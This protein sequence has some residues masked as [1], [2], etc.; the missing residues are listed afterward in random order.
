MGTPSID[1]PRATMR[2]GPPAIA[3]AAGVRSLFVAILVVGAVACAPERTRD[4]LPAPRL[5]ESAD[6]LAERVREEFAHAWQAYAKH[7]WGYDEVLPLSREGHNWYGQSLLITPVDALDA[8]ILL[9]F[10]DEADRVRA[11]VHE[12]L[13]FDI[14]ADVQ[15]FEVTIRVLG[16]LLSGYQLSGDERLLELA[17]DLGRRLLPAFD[18]PTAM[19]YGW[20]NLRTGDV[21]RARTYTAEIG[22][23]ILEFGTLAKLTGEASFYDRPKA[24]LRALYDRRSSIGL[25]G[26]SIDVESGAWID[27]TCHIGGGI[28]SYLEYLW[29]GWRLFGDRELL[30][31]WET[32]LSAFQEHLEVTHHGSLWYARVDMGTGRPRGDVHGALEAFLAGVLAASGDSLRGASLQQSNHAMW[33]IHGLAPERMDFRKMSVLRGH[34]AYHLRPE[35]IESAYQLYRQ[36]RDERYREMGR[37]YL[38]DIVRFCRSEEGYTAIRDVSTLARR[39]AMD[40]YFLSETL[41]YLFLLFRDDVQGMDADVVFT[42]EAHPLRRTW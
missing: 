36:S 4:E 18:S 38:S 34:G 37:Q 10:G 22:T 7:A 8:L 23:L 25:V 3:H 15:V 19:P 5:P 42:T 13:S 41:K 17:A 14:D 21:S 16:G 11:L 24:A 6:A 27:R 1:A 32:Q 28:D 35:V 9:G 12:R 29:K 31:M 2:P 33:S 39:D 20:I 40:S 30:E 26:T